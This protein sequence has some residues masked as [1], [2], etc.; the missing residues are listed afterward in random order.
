[1]SKL[2][3]LLEARARR[4]RGTAREL[5]AIEDVVRCRQGWRKPWYSH[6]SSENGYARRDR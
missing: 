1:M 3:D 5:I 6:G 2:L 4:L